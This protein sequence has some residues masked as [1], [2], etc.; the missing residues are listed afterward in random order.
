MSSLDMKYPAVDLF[1][2]LQFNEM[3]INCIVNKWRRTHDSCT[4]I[5]DVVKRKMKAFCLFLATWNPKPR[6]LV[7]AS[8]ILEIHDVL[9]TKQNELLCF[10]L[11]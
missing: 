8:L 1:D 11:F 3:L 10:I 5:P 7:F 6:V 4:C 9:C 2:V